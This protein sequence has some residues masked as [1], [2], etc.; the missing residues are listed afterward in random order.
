MTGFVK[1]L[2]RV[3]DAV[4]RV[5]KTLEIVL[6]VLMTAVT[7]A[8]MVSRYVFG[9]SLLVGIDELINWT[10][11]WM[12]FIGMGMLVRQGGHIGLEVIFNGMPGPLQKARVL[13]VNIGM[14]CMAAILVRNSIPFLKSQMSITTTSANI[15]KAYLYAAIPAGMTLLAFHLLVQI[16][17]TLWPAKDEAGNQ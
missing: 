10:F 1:K 9:V 2:I 17:K 8:Q 14:I 4:F 13:A 3:E 16:A 15:P 7:T 11:V 5:E 12:V 6:I